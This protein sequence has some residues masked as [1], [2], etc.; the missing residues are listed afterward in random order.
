MTS[1]NIE[2]LSVVEATPGVTPA[3]PRMR[4]RTWTGESLGLKP[5]FEK[6]QRVRDDRM[7][8]DPAKVGLAN[9]G[10][11][12][13]EFSFPTEGSP[14]SVDLESVFGE[15]WLNA[16]FRDNDG[17]A[18]SAILGVDAATQVVTVA[19]GASFPARALV[20]F[21]GFGEAANNALRVV[22]A[23]SAT[24]PAFAASGLV[25]EAA[26]PA[27]ARLKLVGIEGEAGDI[28]AVADGLTSTALD[29]TTFAVLRPGAFIV[30]GGAA[31]ANRFAATA[32]SGW[33]R[34]AAVAAH[35]LTLDNLPAG[36]AADAG[37]GKSIRIALGDDL[38]QGKKII[39]QTLQRRFTGQASPTV[40]IHRGMLVSDYSLSIERQ[41][42][43]KGKIVS[44]QKTFM[45]LDGDPAGVNLDAAPD[46][47]NPARVMAAGVHMGRLYQNGAR[48]TA[49]N[50]VKSVK[51]S[52]NAN[53][54]LQGA[55]DTLAAISHRLGD[56]DVKLEITALFGDAAD[57][58]AFHAG[59][60]LAWNWPMVADGQGV[61]WQFPRLTYT[62]ADGPNASGKNA[63]VEPRFT[64]EASKDAATGSHVVLTRF[65]HLTI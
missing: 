42:A 28:Q 33:A 13:D 38:R 63:T 26:P 12:N 39:T 10:G 61:V 65:E 46:P 35:K 19:A 34:V 59:T 7:N 41:D 57:W 44:V 14:E 1:S 2:I 5:G 17:V 37:A 29:F 4:R 31:A 32:T 50:V 3:T 16:P 47:E 11:L 51:V 25:D 62:D 6:S 43:E 56:L 48:K 9:K 45:G 55:V 49:P 53:A 22:T 23:A 15:N 58:N 64:A 54:A 18:D 52:L 30:V 27:A 20:R 60:P 24:V 21:S 36:W 40:M 8:D